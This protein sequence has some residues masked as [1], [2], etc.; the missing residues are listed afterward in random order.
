ML[1]HILRHE[2]PDSG[3]V[4]DLPG[5]E[6]LCGQ[7]PVRGDGDAIPGAVHVD[8]M[9]RPIESARRPMLDFERF[10]RYGQVET[11]DPYF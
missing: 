9:A 2:L 7:R 3:D 6:D 4:V 10:T 5:S 1:Q 8:D 11:Q